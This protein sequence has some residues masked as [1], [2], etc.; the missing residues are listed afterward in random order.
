MLPLNTK[1]DPEYATVVITADRI[2]DEPEAHIDRAKMM[3]TRSPEEILEGLAAFYRD[4]E[5][6]DQ[7]RESIREC[8]DIDVIYVYRPSTRSDVLKII[9]G[10]GGYRALIENPAFGGGSTLVTDRYILSWIN[11]VERA[12]GRRSLFLLLVD[13]MLP[14][15]SAEPPG[16]G[17]ANGNWTS[18]G[19]AA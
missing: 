16:A 2:R 19:V 6:A 8:G 3:S 1:G 15:K 7:H 14:R 13:D 18:S 10:T 12:T 5:F 11:G 9:T 17:P 4:T